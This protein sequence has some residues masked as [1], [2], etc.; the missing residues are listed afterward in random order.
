MLRLDAYTLRVGEC[1]GAGQSARKPTSCSNGQQCSQRVYLRTSRLASEVS[2]LTRPSYVCYKL[3]HA[4][5][6]LPSDQCHASSAAA[7]HASLG[8]LISRMLSVS[9]KLLEF[10]EDNEDVDPGWMADR[11]RTW[12][13]DVRLV[14]N[15]CN[16][17]EH[18]RSATVLE[19]VDW[20]NKNLDASRRDGMAK[21][22]AGMQKG[23]EQM[24]LKMEAE[25][26]KVK[27]G[28]E[29]KMEE[30]KKMYED[31]L[32]KAGV[33]TTLDDKEVSAALTIPTPASSPA[34]S[35]PAK[36]PLPP[37][38]PATPVPSIAAT[39]IA[40]WKSKYEYIADQN[41]ELRKA[42]AEDAAVED[43]IHDEIEK[44]KQYYEMQMEREK[45]RAQELADKNA[46]MER[47][48]LERGSL[49]KKRGSEGELGYDGESHKRARTF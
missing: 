23:A 48:L 35:T 8:S 19:A 20:Y 39:Q 12:A 21:Y 44:V 13:G 29:K 9:E 49:G 5:S 10:E 16:K 6:I 38:V 3:Q 2:D 47:R 46:E 36:A 30:M 22:R 37:T 40:F 7:P 28:M 32:A 33:D 18:L 1:D 14:L 11:L 34:H 45:A 27:A 24:R 4:D 26:R 43:I 31:R 41:A 17:A 15:K 42:K 25:Q